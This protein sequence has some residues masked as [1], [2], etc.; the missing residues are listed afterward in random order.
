VTALLAIAALT[1]HNKE[2]E[3]KTRPLEGRNDRKG[4]LIDV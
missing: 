4:K 1:A 3:N 2:F